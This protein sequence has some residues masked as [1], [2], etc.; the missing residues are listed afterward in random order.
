MSQGNGSLFENLLKE[1]M[2]VVLSLANGRGN[3]YCCLSGFFSAVNL[4]RFFQNGLLGDHRDPEK[5]Q[6]VI[7][8]SDVNNTTS[9]WGHFEM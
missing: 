4:S 5:G 1:V 3:R 8:G 7:S 2:G 6:S 9:E